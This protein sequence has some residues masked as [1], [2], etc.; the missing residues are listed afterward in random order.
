[1]PRYTRI[2]LMNG[3]THLLTKEESDSLA[4]AKIKGTGVV[5]IERLNVR[6]VPHQVIDFSETNRADSGTPGIEAPAY[7]RPRGHRQYIDAELNVRCTCG[8]PVYSVLVNRMLD[9]KEWTRLSGTPGYNFVYE[10]GGMICVATTRYVC[11]LDQIPEGMTHCTEA[12]YTRF[13]P[14]TAWLQRA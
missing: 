8:R 2:T 1:M 13:R 7:T 9:R 10:D 12:E 5:D 4:Q 14:V 11:G 6:I 3:L